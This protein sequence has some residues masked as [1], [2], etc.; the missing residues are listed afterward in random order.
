MLAPALAALSFAVG[1]AAA[2]ADA[3]VAPPA[4]FISLNTTASGARRAQQLEAAFARDAHGAGVFSRL[5]LVPAVNGNAS[6]RS[7]V[8]AEAQLNHLLKK[9]SM[10]EI[11]CSISHVV[12]IQRAERYCAARGLEMAVIM[13]DDVTAALVPHWTFSLGCAE[14]MRLRRQK[15]LLKVWCTINQSRTVA[16]PPAQSR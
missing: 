16:T 13:E 2:A 9:N 8:H 10:S 5:E 7:F 11:G 6:A 3:R 4:F 14:G 1:A 12:A 15:I